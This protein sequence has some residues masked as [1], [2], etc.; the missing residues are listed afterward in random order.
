MRLLFESANRHSKKGNVQILL[1]DRDMLD[2]CVCQP[3][4]HDCY[5]NQCNIC[6]NRQLF[7][8]NYPLSEI[9]PD[10]MDNEQDSDGDSSSNSDENDEDSSCQV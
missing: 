6:K 4:S 5:F 3:P 1:Y 8:Q 2:E 7:I 9:M 10:D